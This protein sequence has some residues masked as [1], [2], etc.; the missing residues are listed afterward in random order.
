LPARANE[1]SPDT[2][3]GMP[4]NA[5]LPRHTPEVDAA[6]SRA[7]RIR[8]AS[9]ERAVYEER[10]MANRQQRS[11]REK[12]KPKAEK[13]KTKTPA[14]TSAFTSIRPPT[15]AVGQAGKKAP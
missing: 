7:S 5:S 6:P 15:P 11:N 2:Q 9:I 10:A 1:I 12:K 13:N 14:P 8:V 3:P 4:C